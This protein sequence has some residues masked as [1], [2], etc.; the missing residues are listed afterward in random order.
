MDEPRSD[1]DKRMQRLE[2]QLE[3]ITMLLAF[4]TLKESDVDSTTSSGSKG[5]FVP[6]SPK[7]KKS[8]QETT[9]HGKPRKGGLDDISSLL[10][11]LLNRT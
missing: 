8:R 2:E 7:G 6:K 5:M 3:K 4:A 10:D 9:K 11:A 1:I